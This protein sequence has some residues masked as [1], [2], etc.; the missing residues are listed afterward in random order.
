MPPVE[1]YRSEEAYRKAR[2]YTHIHHIPTHATRV[3][4]KGK[5][6]HTVKHRKGK[7]KAQK[8]RVSAKR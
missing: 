2:A 3:C 8:K 5:G 4:I 1:T 7:K 6:C